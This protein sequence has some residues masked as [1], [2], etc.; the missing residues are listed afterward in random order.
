MPCLLLLFY[1]LLLLRNGSM[2]TFMI[3]QGISLSVRI[4]HFLAHFIAVGVVSI[5]GHQ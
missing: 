2:R 5:V 1:I 3:G 4:P